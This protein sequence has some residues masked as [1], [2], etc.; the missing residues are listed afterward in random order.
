M[1][2]TEIYLYTRVELEENKV[3]ISENI[4]NEILYLTEKSLANLYFPNTYNKAGIIN[5]INNLVINK[6]NS[7]NTSIGTIITEK[8]SLVF[9]FNYI[10]KFNDSRP[11]DNLLLTASPTFISGEYL[12]YKNIKITVQI[13]KSNGERIV[14]IEYN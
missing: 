6:D 12:S 2:K 11:Q 1:T 8:G 14:S 5:F 7:F 3:I 9:N 10:L 4:K 13:L